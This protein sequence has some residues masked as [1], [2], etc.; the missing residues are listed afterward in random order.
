MTIKHL[1]AI[2]KLLGTEIKVA[3]VID[4]VENFDLVIT[5]EKV[6]L[7]SAEGIKEIDLE[8]MKENFIKEVE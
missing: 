8:T 7:I 5:K 2:M 4:L 3:K 1:Q 6:S